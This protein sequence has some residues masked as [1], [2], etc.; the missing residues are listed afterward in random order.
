MIE[1]ILKDFN[2]KFTQ[3]IPVLVQDDIENWIKEKLTDFEKNIKQVEHDRI[4]RE[5]AEYYAVY[6]VPLKDRRVKIIKS[7][8]NKEGINIWKPHKENMC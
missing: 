7:D 2:G 3:Y 4:I 8:A 1:E 6:D 5:L